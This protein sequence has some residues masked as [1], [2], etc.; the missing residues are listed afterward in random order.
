[1]KNKKTYFIKTY[2]IWEKLNYIGV[3]F[4]QYYVR[5]II[6]IRVNFYQKWITVTK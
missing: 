1:L 5:V 6:I 4:T 3:K 2:I